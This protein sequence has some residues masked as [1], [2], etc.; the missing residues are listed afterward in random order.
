MNYR[1]IKRWLLIISLANL[2]CQPIPTGIKD[3]QG[4]LVVLDN[5]NINAEPNWRATPIASVKKGDYLILV[6]T[7][8]EWYRV[9]LQNKSFEGWIHMSLVRPT[10]YETI[11]LRQEIELH[12]KNSDNSPVMRRAPAGSRVKILQ[13]TPEWVLVETV[14][15]GAI[16]WVT[17]AKLNAAKGATVTDG[18]TDTPLEPGTILLYTNGEANI[19]TGPGTTHGL[20]LRVQPKT[21]LA[22]RSSEGDW[23][24]VTIVT[25]QQNGYVAKHLVTNP[26]YPTISN[27]IECNLRN[28]P[29]ESYELVDR[30]PSSTSFQLLNSHNE[31]HLVQLNSGNLAWIRS[32]LTNQPIAGGGTISAQPGKMNFGYYFMITN[33]NVHNSSRFNGRIITTLMPGQKVNLLDISDDDWYQVDYGGGQR[34]YVEARN[35]IGI[36]KKALITTQA[37]NLRFGRETNS[38]LIET[39][40]AGTFVQLVE[41]DRNLCKVKA[42]PN[43]GYIAGELLISRRFRSI[44]VNRDNCNYY[45]DASTNSQVAGSLVRGEELFFY[46]EKNNWYQFKLID[47]LGSFWI[48]K[49]VVTLARYGYGLPQQL[50]PI[51]QGPGNQYPQF[52]EKLKSLDELPILA[53]S[54]DW[55][56]IMV[57]N[58]RKMG[59]VPMKAVAVASLRPLIVT[60]T[61]ALRSKRS[62]TSQQIAGV[63]MGTEL[64]ELKQEADWHLAQIQD[65]EMGWIRSANVALTR[66]GNIT[67]RQTTAL[68]AGP[69]NDFQV[70]LSLSSGS[71]VTIIDFV[72][73]WYQIDH[74]N[75]SGWIYMR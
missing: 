60:K 34:G 17:R 22:W 28:G 4:T 37:A 40:P 44:F 75:G 18:A 24:Y 61:A 21:R 33:A 16:G 31:W 23:F 70:R 9:R 57:P 69:G 73:D 55:Y 26:P 58:R 7:Q 54:L 45:A 6:M 65:G 39:L 8:N 14:P 49:N 38:A 10:R 46:N 30:I 3:G 25:T 48:Q 59:W 67:L 11:S 63:E 43:Q 47:N 56:Q 71:Q 20:V 62:E 27:N 5:A 68:R 19:R 51:Y 36:R 29:G 12:Y 64:I 50:S 1:E 35:M 66:Y 15:D 13:E 74:P 53:T 41:I 42:G 32:D 52:Q 72:G 2:A